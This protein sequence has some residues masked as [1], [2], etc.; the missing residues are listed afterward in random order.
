MHPSDM[1]SAQELSGHAAEATFR[2]EVG[3]RLGLD[4]PLRRGNADTT[5]SWVLKAIGAHHALGVPQLAHSLVEE[6][7][8]LR[9][10]WGEGKRVWV[11]R[12]L[13]IPPLRMKEA[14]LIG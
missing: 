1:H 2:I 13:Q 8:S 7:L 6:P 3:F 12:R 9:P 14:G 11:R 4:R 10:L 5:V